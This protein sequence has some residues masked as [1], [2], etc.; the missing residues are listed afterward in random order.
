MITKVRPPMKMQCKSTTCLFAMAMM[1]SGCGSDK[2]KSNNIDIFVNRADFQS[3]VNGKQTDLF[4]LESDEGI[5]LAITNFGGRVVSWMVPGKDG[6]YADISVGFDNVLA[7]QNANESYYGALIGRVG[8]RIDEGAF[9]L[10]GE[11]YTLAKNNGSNS[12]HGGP[13]GFHNVVWNAEQIDKKKLKLTY[14]SED[15]EEGFPGTLDVEVLYSVTD[16]NELR[17]EYTATTDKETIVNLT[18]H[19]FF[20]L[21]G[22]AGGPINDH[23]LTINADS[24]TPVD[25]TLIPRGE[26]ALV[27]GTP[28]DFRHQTPIG[29]RVNAD[30]TQLKYGNG[31]DHN[32]VLNKNGTDLTLAAKVHE[33][34]SGRTMEILTTEP[35][36]QFYSGNFMDSSD[37]GKFGKALGFREAFC[38]EPQHFPDAPNQPDFPDISLKPG[39]TYITVS[40]YRFSI[41]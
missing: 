27:E 19:T 13:G 38:L 37:I 5:K 1:I 30:N 15:G 26:I 8:N 6:E 22:E 14:T 39:E 21:K 25:S 31:Y 3:T 40:V 34:K 7:Y 10:N 20:N 29:E 23:L 35:G 2:S 36:I 17:I 24:Y 11:E 16:N 32:F 28:F 9:S 4:I 41:E 33:P 18:N 12:L